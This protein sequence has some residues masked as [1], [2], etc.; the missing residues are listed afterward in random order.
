M[1][2]NI[3]VLSPRIENIHFPPASIT[4]SGDVGWETWRSVIGTLYFLHVYQSSTIHTS[5]YTQTS[6]L[7]ILG[8]RHP[9]TSIHEIRAYCDSAFA[10]FLAYICSDLFCKPRSTVLPQVRIGIKI[11]CSNTLG[12][13]HTQK[14][15]SQS[16]SRIPAFAFSH[17]PSFLAGIR[18]NADTLQHSVFYIRRL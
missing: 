2:H 1:R 6:A 10:S 15:Y 18:M 12:H 14:I 11:Q 3:Y 4:H 13:Y 5:L 8:E 17:S 16:H 7:E 9:N